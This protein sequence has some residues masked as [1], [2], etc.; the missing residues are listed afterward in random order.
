MFTVFTTFGKRS[1]GEVRKDMIEWIEENRESFKSHTISGMA[2]R[3]MSF[4]TWFNNVISNDYIGDEFCLSALC[5]MCQR[6][7]LVVTS[8]KV[9]TT[10]PAS[11]QKNR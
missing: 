4:D 3:D 6:H 9:W 11:F 5:Q 7:T 2:S 10:I 1:P 8:V